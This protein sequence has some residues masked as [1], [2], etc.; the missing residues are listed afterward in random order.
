MRNFLKSGNYAT[1]RVE[2]F[3]DGVFAIIVTLLV[4][5]LHVP[6]LILPSSASLLSAL[7]G[8]APKFIIYAIG[9]INITVYWI[10][11][12][13]L[14]SVLK[15]TDVG[16]LWL[17]C[18]LL[19][20]L[21][22]VP[23]PTAMLGTYPHQIVAVALFG[24]VMILAAICFGSMRLYAAY[25][26]CLIDC[27]LI[28]ICTLKTNI[29][30]SYSGAFFYLIAILLGLI[31]TYLSIILFLIIPVYYAFPDRNLRG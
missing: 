24:S 13:Q 27:E 11:H 20:I 16:F 21:A 28:N 29:V 23:F 12:H 1:N 18:L 4:L 31:N 26:S 19:L 6:D 8:L 30:K 25:T 9:F 3:S 22:F 17:N 15:K 7:N 10:N 5:E 2:A 14:F